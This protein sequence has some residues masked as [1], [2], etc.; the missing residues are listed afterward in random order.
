MPSSVPWQDP[1]LQQERKKDHYSHFILHLAFSATEDLRR[2]FTR[3]EAALFRLRFQSDDARERKDFVESLDL[4]WDLVSEDERRQL[5]TRLRDATPRIKQQEL[6]EGSW[7]KVDFENVP[8]LV[9]R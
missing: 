4:N 8:E 7:F 2:Q 3:V 9:E 6:D 1:T 5:A